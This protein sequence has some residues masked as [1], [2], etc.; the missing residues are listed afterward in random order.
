MGKLCPRRTGITLANWLITPPPIVG[1]KGASLT[2]KCLLVGGSRQT[3]SRQGATSAGSR[4]GATSAAG[5]RRKASRKELVLQ[6]VGK[7]K[8]VQRAAGR[9]N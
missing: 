9:Y 6:S 2:K 5:S 4:E 3:G 1:G 7:R 8:L